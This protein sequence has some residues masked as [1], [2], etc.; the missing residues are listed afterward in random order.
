MRG[1][2]LVAVG[3]VCTL[4]LC[5]YLI[6]YFSSDDVPRDVKATVLISWVLGFIGMILLPYDISLAL[7]D[8][9]PG[10]GAADK[11]D[12]SLPWSCL[13]WT[14]FFWSWV[15]LPLQHNYHTSGAF[16]VRSKVKDALK[17][18][19]R[20][21]TFIVLAGVVYIVYTAVSESAEIGAVYALTMALG[22]TYGVLLFVVLAGSGMVALP[23][24]LWNLSDLDLSLRRVRIAAGRGELKVLD[25]QH[26]LNEVKAEVLS[27]RGNS[28][29]ADSDAPVQQLRALLGAES[30]SSGTAVKEEAYLVEL[31]VRLK[32]C[33]LRKKTCDQS[34]RKLQDDAW[35]LEEAME[36]RDGLRSMETAGQRRVWCFET[37][38]KWCVTHKRFAL[39]MIS[40]ELILC[41]FVLL[42][43]EILIPTSKNSPIGYII[44]V[45]KGSAADAL[46][47]QA[48]ASVVIIYMT[49]CA[50]FTLF[51]LGLGWE[52]SLVG[53]RRSPLTALIFNGEYATRIQ[54]SICYNF[55][56]LSHTDR[57]GTAS[58][59]G[60]PTGFQTIMEKMETTPLLGA[61][62]NTYVPVTMVL[63]AVLT[64]FQLYERMLN[65]VPGWELDDYAGTGAEEEEEKVRMGK[66]LL[67]SAKR[68]GR[69]S[70]VMQSGLSSSPSRTRTAVDISEM[71]ITSY[72]RLLPSD[73]DELGDGGSSELTA[74]CNPLGGLAVDDDDDE[75]E[76]G[77]VFSGGRYSNL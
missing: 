44:G 35:E 3:V 45:Y 20:Y 52:Y 21:Y 1:L 10:R 73:A 48:Y 34:W 72:N 69:S 59:D 11:N 25:A 8:A 18:T 75:E 41:S 37:V 40:L 2:G 68:K 32:T 39:R 30:A 29:E 67:A 22:N 71:K 51:T 66:M 53:P 43:C 62:V 38:C 70:T 46:T 50:Y 56:L 24:H 16:T 63:I 49:A 65:M 26:E 15:V 55:L 64:Y 27:L 77:E 60:S 23:K 58:G 14:T 57:L 12:L 61:D 7:T 33:I 19:L 47:V 74:V 4:I 13:Y 5:L 54:F 6:T 17:R 28:N 42:W 36:A 9:T 76:E 31:H